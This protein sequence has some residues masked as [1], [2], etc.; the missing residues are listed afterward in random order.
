MKLVSFDRLEALL[1]QSGMERESTNRGSL[2]AAK[3]VLGDALKKE[4]TPRQLE[5]V[6]L[7][8]YENL[9]EEETAACLGITRSTVCRHLQKA[10]RRLEKAVS[11]AG[12]ACRAMAGRD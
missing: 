1:G 5:C 6:R 11:Y 12:T 10:L 4:L 8:Y 9:T 2:L 7:Y 3:A